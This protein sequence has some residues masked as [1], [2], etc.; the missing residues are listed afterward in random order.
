MTMGSMTMGS[1]TMGSMGC[2][3]AAGGTPR[4]G[5]ARRTCGRP[6]PR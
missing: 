4:S 5:E 3:G 6:H 2:S 1:M